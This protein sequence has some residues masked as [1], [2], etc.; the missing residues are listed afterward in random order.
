MVER[1]PPPPLKKSKKKII[2]YPEL[3][4]G[5]VTISDVPYP[6]IRNYTSKIRKKWHEHN[7]C[8]WLPS[9]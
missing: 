8:R 9:N 6:E 5:S 3:V 7:Y 2:I 4:K 1:A